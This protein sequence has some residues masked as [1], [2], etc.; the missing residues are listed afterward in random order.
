MGTK[1]WSDS[2]NVR[3]ILIATN[4]PQNGQQLRDDSLAKKLIDSI[5]AAIK[6]G[7]SFEALC[8]KYSDDGASKVKGGNLGM[9]AQAQ[10][11]PTFNDFAFDNPVGTKGLW[12][13]LC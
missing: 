1:Q 6:G 8:T 13:S 5:S 4:N 11:V 2:S 3:H 7:A 10:M 12:I 9:F